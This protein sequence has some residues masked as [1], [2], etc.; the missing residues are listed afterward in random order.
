MNSYEG[1]SS[2]AKTKILAYPIDS[3]ENKRVIFYLNDAG[4]KKE[5]NNEHLLFLS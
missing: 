3:H 5:K 2:Q 4:L 1:N